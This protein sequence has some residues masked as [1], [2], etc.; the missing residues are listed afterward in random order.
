MKKRF[1]RR[2]WFIVLVVLAVVLAAASFVWS[3]S[4]V[5]Q[6]AVIRLVCLASP[7][8][9]AKARE[10][11]VASVVLLDEDVSYESRFDNGTMD[12]YALPS[13][14]VQPLIVYAHGGYYIGGDKSSLSDYC[15][16]LASY[17]YVVANLNYMLAPDGL[18]PTQILQ[19]NEAIGYLLQHAEEYGFDAERIFIAG[20]SAGGHLASQMGLYYTNLAFQQGIGD[21]PAISAEQLCGVVLHCGYYNT[22]TVAATGFPM[23]E[24]SIWMLT[25]VKDYEGTQVAAQMNTVAQVTAAYPAVFIDCGDQD[26][27]ITQAGELIAALTANGVP[28]T[29]YLPETDQI[30]LMHE[31]QLMLNTAEGMEAMERLVGFLGERSK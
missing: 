18:Y 28:V 29:S 14:E 6:T 2:W 22:D 31:F 3:R 1:Y 30:P 15:R 4:D 16:T 27:F 25:G 9:A 24:D 26:P 13:D 12:V 20:D 5:L 21:V 10:K 8:G 23:I 19:V 7:G 11:A 17:G